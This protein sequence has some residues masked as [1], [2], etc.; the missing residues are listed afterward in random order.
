MRTDLLGVGAVVADL[1]VYPAVA[2]SKDLETSLFKELRTGQAVLIG[3]SKAEQ[4]KEMKQRTYE[5][6]NAAHRP[7]ESRSAF[8]AHLT[9]AQGQAFAD[10][11]Q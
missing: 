4:D 9:T 10:F 6:Q 11:F 1:V 2:D 7:E 3:K 8:K 5:G